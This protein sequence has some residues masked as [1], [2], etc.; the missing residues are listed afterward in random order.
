MY[1]EHPQTA[2]AY[3]PNLWWYGTP[4]YINIDK[5]TLLLRYFQRVQF[6]SLTIFDQ[7]MF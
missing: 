5:S 4:I 1:S 6:S 7:K 3:C 2:P